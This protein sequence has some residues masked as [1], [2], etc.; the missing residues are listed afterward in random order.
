MGVVELGVGVEEEVGEVVVDGRGVRMVVDGV[1]FCIVQAFVGT[2]A[3]A[4]R[5]VRVGLDVVGGGC[6]GDVRFVLFGVVE[7]VGGTL[8]CVVGLSM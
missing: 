5:G 6:R 1:D 4:A 3:P 8:V 2:W 7:V